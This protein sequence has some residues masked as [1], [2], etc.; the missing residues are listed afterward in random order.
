MTK[1]LI[2]YNTCGISGKDNTDFYLNAIGT[3]LQQEF[4]D[5]DIVVSSCLNTQFTIDKIYETYKDKLSI[6]WT[7]EVLPINTTFNHSILEQ[8]KRKGKYDGYFLMDSDILLQ[9]TS[10][11]YNLFSILK[12]GPNGMVSARTN[13]DTGLSWWFNTDT[14]QDLIKNGNFTVP[15]GKAIN[16]H[17]QVYSSEFFDFY[18]KILC[19]IF[20]GYC[21]ESVMTFVCSAIKQNWILSKDVLV[22]HH[23]CMDGSSSGFDPEEWRKT[24]NHYDHPFRINSIMDRVA[25]DEAKKLGL[26]YEEWLKIVV[27]DPAQY[28]ENGFCINDE[29]KNYIKDNLYLKNNE[30]N[31]ED[32]EHEFIE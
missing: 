23:H 11:V 24:R 26:G 27:H 18:G 17:F 13:T 29:L 1:A 21:S 6:N 9:K 31:Y 28:D 8:V 3:I 10:D 14:Y 30:L 15:L 22:Y 5:F 7:K 4:I 20:A 25:S 32:I 12:S 19:D 2:I 16:S